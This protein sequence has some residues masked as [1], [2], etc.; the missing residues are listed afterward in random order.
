MKLFL[1]LHEREIIK[2]SIVG[3]LLFWA[4]VVSIALLMKRDHLVVVKVDEYGTTV[5]TDSSPLVVSLETENFLN[6]FVG[7]FY[8]YT[9][10]NFDS[11]IERSLEFLDASVADK[12]I[13][14]LNSMSDKV[15]TRQTLQTATAAKIVKVKDGHYQIEMVVNRTTGNE[16]SPDSYKLDVE[17]ERTHRSLENPYGMLITKLEEVYE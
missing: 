2:Y 4:L 10:E 1:R 8:N 11:H 6:N 14:K 13:P 9:S 7:L 3:V 16:E 15:K 12:F 17:L 5:L